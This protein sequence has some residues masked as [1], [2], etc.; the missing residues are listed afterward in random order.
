MDEVAEKGVAAHYKY[1]EGYKRT[2]MTVTEQWVTQI[3]E[4][5]EGQ[6]SL[7]TNELLDSI[8]LNLYSKEVFVF[9]PKGEIKLLPSGSTALDF[10][11]SVHTD[12]GMK[13]LG[14]KVNGKLVPISYVLANG[15]R[16][17][18]LTSNNQKPKADWLDFVVTSKAKAKLKQLSILTKVRWWKKEKRF[19]SV[20]CAMLK[21]RIQTMKSTSY[22]SF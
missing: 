14:A 7:S 5:L 17:D 1:K 20:K 19:C 22:K 3:R 18:I 15:D 4:V 21:L 9:T 13:C 2:M 16:I 11:F 6:Q 10:A 12:L 8:K